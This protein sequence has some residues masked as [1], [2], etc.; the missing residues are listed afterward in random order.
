MNSKKNV[1]NI[2][3]VFASK[4]G[5]ILVGVYFLPFFNDVLGVDSF[6]IVAV[7][8]SLQSLLLMLDL[9]MSTLVGRDSVILRNKNPIIIIR[10]AEA[11]ISAMYCIILPVALLLLWGEV[12]SI[13][14]F[15]LICIMLMFWL[16]TLQNISLSALLAKQEYKVASS[17]QVVGAIWKAIFTLVILINLEAT[18]DAFIIAQL[19]A[20][21]INFSVLK[22][23]CSSRLSTSSLRNSSEKVAL[24]ACIE[25]AKRGKPLIF[26]SIAGA[27]VLQLDKSIVTFFMSAKE[28]VPYFLASSFCMLPIAV[29]AA[30]IRQFFQPKVLKAYASRDDIGFHLITKLYVRTLVTIVIFFTGIIWLFNDSIINLWL[31]GNEVSPNVASLT[32][33]LLPALAIG[34]FG[35]IPYV[36]I[37]IA[38]DYKFQAKFSI[39]MTIITLLFV[40]IFANNQ[41]IY[42]ITISYFIYHFFS[43]VGLWY[44]LYLLPNMRE[45]AVLSA[46][47]FIKA[48]IINISILMIFAFGGYH[49]GYI[50]N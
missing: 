23:F 37:I 10:E 40:I 27:A 9:G 12:L 30:P 16:L 35:F 24:N 32:D 25:L 41:N 47:T 29:L 22:F 6:G 8:L 50:Y 48:V 49:L 2:L 45:V 7:I 13:S 38:E 36:F 15:S 34:A 5:G 42:L 4:A 17:I 46:S 1:I 3:F 44:R 43:S 20:T 26:S 33:I 39:V 21:V 18:V 28:L 14:L 11:V 19:L 31:R